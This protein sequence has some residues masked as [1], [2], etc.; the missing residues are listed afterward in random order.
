MDIR[1]DFFLRHVSLFI[2]DWP[3]TIVQTSLELAILLPQPPE[4]TGICH[5]PSLEEI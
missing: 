1:K 4:I 2:P 3:Q 5:H